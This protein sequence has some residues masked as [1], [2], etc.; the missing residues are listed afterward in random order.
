MKPSHIHEKKSAR[1]F[2]GVTVVMFPGLVALSIALA[3]PPTSR[4]E[5]VSLLLAQTN[6]NNI[7]V[8]FTQYFNFAFMLAGVLAFG[9]IVWGAFKYII[10]AG[11]PSGQS[12]ARDQVLQAI[13]GLLLLVGA[14]LILRTI[15]PN[16]ASIELG[17]LSPLTA[18][19]P[20]A[21]GTGAP[22]AGC[23]DLG[24]MAASMRVPYPVA[25]DQDVWKLVNCITGKVKG[26]AA[27]KTLG[28]IFT[29][30]LSNTSCNY[31]RGNPVCTPGKGCSHSAYSCHY[32][33]RTGTSGALAVDFGMQGG[34][35][36]VTPAEEQAMRAA[37]QACSPGSKF[38]KERTC[39]ART[40]TCYEHIHISLAKCDGT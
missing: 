20:P 37:A 15:D 2:L 18:P 28:S 13:I 34:S 5:D 1:K 12:D 26:N 19:K 35:A 6:T 11:N 38:L 29:A 23:S 16:L 36:P 9:A 4:A 22:A 30:D 33:G 17:K 7:G 24:A 8:L 10:A 3:W 32:G 21:G 27:V 14:G 39:D 40:G 31:T 25:V